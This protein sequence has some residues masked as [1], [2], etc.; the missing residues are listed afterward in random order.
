MARSRLDGASGAVADIVQGDGIAL[1]GEQD[2][3][4]TGTAAIEHLPQGYAQLLGFVLGDGMPLGHGGSL[5]MAFSRPVYQRP[6]AAGDR[7]ARKWNCA[8]ASVL[9]LAVKATR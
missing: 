2:A 6:A 7:S 4:D 8:M 3:K 5:A 9:A 1:D